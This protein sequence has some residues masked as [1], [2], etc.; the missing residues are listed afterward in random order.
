MRSS[1]ISSV[2]DCERFT[3]GGNGE[4][5]ASANVCAN[6]SRSRWNVRAVVHVTPS[7]AICSPAPT[8]GPDVEHVAL[9]ADRLGADEV[10]GGRWSSTTDGTPQRASSSAVVCPTGPAPTTSTGSCGQL[11][12]S[13]AAP[14]PPGRARP[15]RSPAARSR[16]ARPTAAR[17]RTAGSARR[18]ASGRTARCRAAWQASNASLRV[19]PRACTAPTSR[20]MTSRKWRVCA[21]AASTAARP[22]LTAPRP[23]ISASAPSAATASSVADAQSRWK[24]SPV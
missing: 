22:R 9:L 24:A 10:A 18:S 15:S 2:R 21:I 3:N 7:A 4:L 11:V 6:S 16:T 1:R 19:P 17:R 20:I 13:A 8:D 12:M 5:P 14:R 23:P